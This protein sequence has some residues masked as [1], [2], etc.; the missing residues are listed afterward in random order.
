MKKVLLIDGA[1]PI[2]TRSERIVKT[3]R[4]Y[5]KVRIC[6]WNR[7]NT[8]IK[9]KEE[10]IY[11]SNEGYGNKIKK[12]QGMKKYLEFIKEILMKYNPDIIIA[13]QWDML[14]LIILSGFKGKIIYE[15]I[16]L[17]T[18]TNIFLLKILLFL[19]KYMLKKVTGII[20]ASRFFIPLYSKYKIKG[21]LLENLPI[22]ENDNDEYEIIKREKLRISFIGTLRYFETMKNL[23]LASQDNENIEV[24]LIGKG[25]E[26]NKFKTFIKENK[27][28]NIFMIDSYE[29]RDI[30]RLYLNTDLVW[31]VYP[32]KDYNVKYAISNKFFESILYEKPCFFAKDT[33]L[34]NFVNENKIGIIVNP[35]NVNEIKEKVK[36]LNEEKILSLQKNLKKY[37]QDKKIYWEDSE[38]E[39]INFINEI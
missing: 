19:E 32:N 5:Y 23:L 4:K 15:N 17:P 16:D 7:E 13:S 30:K 35:Y 9:N 29:Y 3:L 24:Y 12:L 34:G 18:S 6:G 14:F 11:S 37:K 27:M 10:Y 33:F 36:S 20:Y 1:Y 26:N 22:K 21:L 28:K 38:K 8:T 39:L 25:P 31:A 2:N